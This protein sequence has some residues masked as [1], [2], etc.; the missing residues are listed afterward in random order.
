MT[1]SR[2]KLLQRHGD[3]NAIFFVDVMIV[4]IVTHRDMDK[5]DLA[6]KGVL[7]KAIKIRADGRAILFV[8]A[9]VGSE[10]QRLG[11]INTAVCNFITVHIQRSRNRREVPLY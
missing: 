2:N 7:T 6:V 3:A 8:N 5:I 9:G 10:N 4:D 1:F 11:I